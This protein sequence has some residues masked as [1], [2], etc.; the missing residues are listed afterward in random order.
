MAFNKQAP[1]WGAIGIEPPE[2]KRNIGWEV[3]DRPPAAWLNWFMNLTAE[4]LQELQSK[5]AEKT[6]VEDKIAEAIAGIDVDIPD[7][8]L[9]VKG[10]IQLNSAVNSTSETEAAT[11][12][13][14]KMAY[15]EAQAGKQ[16]GNERKA[17]VVAALIA[18]GIH[19]TTD[20]LWA[21][22][23]PK[24]TAIVTATGT[25]AL[26]DVL[27]GK[28]FST[29]AGNAMVGTMPN[30]AGTLQGSTGVGNGAGDVTITPPIG[31]YDG[32]A[33]T[34]VKAWDPNFISAN[35]RAGTTIFGVPGSPTVVDTA[36]GY[37]DPNVILKGNSGWWNGKWFE[38]AMPN[39]S[40]EN[41]HM[42]AIA[43]TVFTG[44]RVFLQ[45]PHGFYNGA[46]WVAT[47]APALIPGNIK[48]GVDILG[49]VGTASTMKHDFTQYASFISDVHHSDFKPQKLL[50]D[51]SIVG[52]TTG[53]EF[54]QRDRNGNR[55]KRI[56][57][58]GMTY[59]GY[60]N[61]NELYYYTYLSGTTNIRVCNDSGTILKGG[62][63]NENE[64][65]PLIADGDGANTYIYGNTG[66]LHC[67]TKNLVL[68]KSISTDTQSQIGNATMTKLVGDNLYLSGMYV[69]VAFTAVI[70]IPAQTIK[71]SY[72]P[73]ALFAL[74]SLA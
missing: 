25:A 11:P 50:D 73:L 39:R 37:L 52:R 63:V 16:A 9:T 53:S 20:E 42:P 74:Q 23:I 49:M 51:G 14:V 61:S 3:E 33:N 26:A 17:E 64:G 1:K 28:T 4:S 67:L 8:S 15:D 5:A 66:K 19:A 18:K 57:Y 48:K 46:S 71:V 44:D 56:P 59:I 70:N 35:I 32:K 27:A 12:K 54:E 40:A 47:P 60:I 2:S 38:G 41:Q 36:I 13:A 31:Y 10:I 69:N 30:R 72:A 65:T 43:A 62:E 68:V 6:Y 29:A 58:N 45:P 34:Q 7:A 22:L 55:S 24:I 21:T